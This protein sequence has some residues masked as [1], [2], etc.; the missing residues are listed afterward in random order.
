MTSFREMRKKHG[1]TS[2]HIA[3]YLGIK[4]DTLNAKERGDRAW[5]NKELIMLSMKYD[6]KD[7]TNISDVK[8]IVS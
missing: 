6:I 5:N 3:D 4:V 2:K 1:F 8:K 7:I